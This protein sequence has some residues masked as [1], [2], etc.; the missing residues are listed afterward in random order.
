MMLEYSASGEPLIPFPLSYAFE[1]FSLLVRRLREQEQGKGIPEGFVSS[2]TYWLLAEDSTILGVSNL[3]HRLTPKLQIEGGHIGYG[4]R[5]SMRGR[6]YGHHLLRLTLAAAREYEISEVLLTC[7][8][9]NTASRAVIE[10]AGGRF[11]D[12]EFVEAYGGVVRRYWIHNPAGN[13]AQTGD[14]P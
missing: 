7:N 9:E 12:E 5:P 8:R 4:I 1:D 10:R 11:Q 3:R 2:S 6:G 13:V 14:E